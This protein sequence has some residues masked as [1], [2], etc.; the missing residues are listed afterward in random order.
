MERVS[1]RKLLAAGSGAALASTLV[2]ATTAA[3]QG[4]STRPPGQPLLERIERYA[5]VLNPP[6]SDAL[7]QPPAPN[8][9]PTGPVYFTGTLWDDGGV[10]AD[11]T[12]AGDAL[13][14][15]VYRAYGWVYVP[16]AF[17]QFTA[18]HTFDLFGRGQV[19]AAGVTDVSTAITGG[20]G[21]FQG[22]RGEIRMAV[23][24]STGPALT[25]EFDMV[26]P[27]IGR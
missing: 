2:G 12:P 26:A 22:A 18:V 21:E 23:L 24:S 19:T 7:R 5:L 8:Q 4:H 13:Q 1:R 6:G 17:P 16:G 10:G 27:N 14:R 9:A 3:A 20:T 15:G 25:M 11:G